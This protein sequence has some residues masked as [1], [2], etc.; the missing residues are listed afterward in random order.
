EKSRE[1]PHNLHNK[2]IAVE[3]SVKFV[4]NNKSFDWNTGLDCRQTGLEV[5]NHSHDGHRSHI[6]RKN[7]AHIRVVEG[8][9]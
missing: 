4:E 5:D 8:G 1:D 3:N 7:M 9:L 2:D 6:T